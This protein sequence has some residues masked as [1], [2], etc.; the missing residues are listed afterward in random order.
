MHLAITDSGLGGLSVCA[1]IERA[2][3]E[4]RATEPLQITYVNAWPEEGRGYN[5]FALVSERATVFDRALSAIDRLEPDQIL[6]ACNTLSIL[7]SAT[8]RSHVRGGASVHGII[9]AG[10]DLFERALREHPAATLVIVGTRTTVESGVHR[11]ALLRRGIDAER[12]AGASCH[13]LATAIEQ[14]VAGAAAAELIEMCAERAAEA[15][16]GSGHVFLGLCCTHYGMVAGRLVTALA[17]HVPGPVSALDPNLALVEEVLMALADGPHARDSEASGQRNETAAG[18]T[19]SA[20][21]STNVRV[22]SKVTLPEG[23]REN[24]ASI[25]DSVSHA[26]AEALRNYTHVPEMF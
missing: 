9:D 14:D 10:V 15:M 2:W 8:A 16:K 11:D 7:Y 21:A 25:L 3:R 1:A 26:T 12:L 5:D 17:A 6:I 24:V 19:T 4:S 23:K 20:L 22:V 18:K 13:G